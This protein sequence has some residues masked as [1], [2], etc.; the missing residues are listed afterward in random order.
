MGRYLFPL[1]IIVLVMGLSL[2]PRCRSG[3]PFRSFSGESHFLTCPLVL[4]NYSTSFRYLDFVFGT[5]D[6][7]RA[8]KARVK[9]AKQTGESKAALE[10]R[11]LAETEKEGI[12]AEEKA[13]QG[14]FRMSK[15]KT[16]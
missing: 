11:L 3:H 8:Y 2:F 7:Y 10:K 14:G 12:I 1:G 4:Q 5:D 15:G 9:T 6:K 16:E 13:A